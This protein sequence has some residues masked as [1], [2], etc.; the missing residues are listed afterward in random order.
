MDGVN[1]VGE[2]KVSRLQMEGESDD[3]T[4]PE[5]KVEEETYCMLFLL[6]PLTT[7]LFFLMY[8]FNI[9]VSGVFFCWVIFGCS[10]VLLTFDFH[11]S[12]LHCVIVFTARSTTKKTVQ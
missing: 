7:S 6:F 11:S 1:E 10:L 8:I 9:D 5:H 12:V 3:K 2:V 4:P